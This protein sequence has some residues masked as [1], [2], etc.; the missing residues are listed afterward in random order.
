MGSSYIHQARFYASFDAILDAFR[1]QGL[2]LHPLRVVVNIAVAKPCL[3]PQADP[4]TRAGPN[5][6]L[7]SISMYLRMA[8]LYDA[9][10]P[11]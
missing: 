5:L 3:A 7:A 9:P 8:I 10:L 1:A 2:E 6:H 4:R 11:E